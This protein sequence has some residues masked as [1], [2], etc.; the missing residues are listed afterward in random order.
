MLTKLK[1]MLLQRCPCCCSG[2]MFSGLFRMHRKCGQ[3]GLD[4]EPEPGYYIGALYMNYFLGLLFL[5]PMVGWMIW[6]DYSAHAIGAASVLGLVVM[7]PLV[8]RYARVL[9]IYM[10]MLLFDT[11]RCVPT[12]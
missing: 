5:S 11:K 12:K 9:W 2:A 7:A 8:F 4:L 3:C 10:D 6:R 1:G